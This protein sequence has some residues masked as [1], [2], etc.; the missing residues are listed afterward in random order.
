MNPL[1][2]HLTFSSLLLFLLFAGFI[3]SCDE[4]PESYDRTNGGNVLMAVFAH[5]DDETLVSSVLHQYANRGY[6]VILVTATD[7][8]LGFNE[9][10]DIEDEDELAAVRRVELQCAAEL[11]GAEL[12]HLDYEDQLGMRDGHGAIISQ[13]RGLKQDLHRLFEEYQPDVIITFGPDG[14]SNHLD[15]RMVGIATT[16]VF[17]S[18]E[19]DFNPSL[20]FTGIPTS[21]LDDDE[22]MFMGV[23]D[24]YMTVEIKFSDEEADVAIQS[25]L[26]HESQFSP[27]FV[28]GW[29]DRLENWGNR[30]YFRPFTPSGGQS[31]D[32]FEKSGR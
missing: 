9:N 8:R 2:K 19:W 5:P 6:Y 12:I 17:L 18:R 13:T 30:L 4:A 14:F 21:L 10:T 27:E 3:S 15:H 32:L 20:F 1:S 11:L 28:Y 26:C 23:D 24:Q 7:G 25:A 22:W 16:Q 31:S 29:F